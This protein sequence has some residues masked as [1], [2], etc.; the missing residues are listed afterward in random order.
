MKL[1][2]LNLILK[3]DLTIGDDLRI[4]L[5]GVY[6]ENIPYPKDNAGKDVEGIVGYEILRGSREGNKSI[7]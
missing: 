1:C 2:I 4:R 6:F 3:V 7:V 5:M